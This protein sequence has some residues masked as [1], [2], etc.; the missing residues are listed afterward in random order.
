MRFILALFGFAIL[1]APAAA[2]PRDWAAVVTP[3][4]AGTFVIG[5]PAAKVK[6]VEYVSYTCPHCARFSADSA[7]VLRDRMVRSGTTST[8]IRHQI[9]DALDLSAA[10]VARCGGART[11]VPLSTAIWA[12][13]ETWLPRG[14][15]YQQ[16]NAAR[17]ERYPLNAQLKA[18][19]DGAGLTAIGRTGGLTDAHLAACFATA[20]V[21]D[22]A[23]AISAAAPTEVTGTPTFYINGKLVSPRTWAELEPL[24][25][26]AGAR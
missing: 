13:Q 18:L 21:A 26:A 20:T 3:T 4:P 15:A 14:A 1:A 2:A 22:K 24:L 12:Q 9:H 19:A 25:R 11:F 8:E 6:L 17:L 10:V 16:S 5:N 23:V 7:P